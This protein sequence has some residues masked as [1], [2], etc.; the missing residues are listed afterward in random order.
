MK[1]ILV[2]KFEHQSLSLTRLQEVFLAAF[3]TEDSF[4]TAPKETKKNLELLFFHLIQ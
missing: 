1:K 2:E 3:L 4:V